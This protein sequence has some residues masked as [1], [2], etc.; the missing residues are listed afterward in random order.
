MPPQIRSCSLAY[1]YEVGMMVDNDTMYRNR[2]LWLSE[3]LLGKGKLEFSPLFLGFYP[4]NLTL[5]KD[6]SYYH[7]AAVQ[8]LTVVV[9]LLVSL[10]MV[11]RRIGQWLRYNSAVWGGVTFSKMVLVEW[12]FYLTEKHSVALKQQ[13][14]TNSIRAALDEDKFQRSKVGRTRTQRTKL[15]T[16]RVF[17]SLVVFVAVILCYYVIIVVNEHHQDISDWIENLGIIRQWNEDISE[18]I[19]NFVDTLTVCIGLL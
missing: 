4:V 15:Y 18:F 5:G 9:T 3:V 11:V 19:I 10:V 2:T 6:G 13:I 7:L 16:K 1:L 12:D 8:V 17:V 14:L